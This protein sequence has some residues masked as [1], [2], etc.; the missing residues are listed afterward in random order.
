MVKSSGMTRFALV[1]ILLA[2]GCQKSSKGEAPA[3]SAAPAVA[4]TL[5]A[6]GAPA[7]KLV[8]TAHNGE[9]VDLE[10]FRGKP[11]VVYF[12]PKDDTPGCTVEAKGIRDEWKDL[13]AAG[14]IVIGVST[15]DN[16]SHKAFADKYQLPFLLIPDPDAK[17]TAEFG[18]PLRLGHA[19]RV[20]FVIGKDG[21]IAKVFPDVNPDGHARELVAAIREAG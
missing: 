9:R 20:T 13:Q 18:V 17:I 11:V 7:P 21:K 3:G 2:V 1:L 10:S 6:V 14:A 12:Y 5:L 16:E 19:S 8:A 4:T 15:D